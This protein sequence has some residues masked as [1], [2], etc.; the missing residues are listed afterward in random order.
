MVFRRSVFLGEPVISRFV[1]KMHVKVVLELFLDVLEMLPEVLH[2]SWRSWTP[3]P[4]LFAPTAL[5]KKIQALN[6]FWLK[7]GSNSHGFGR[8]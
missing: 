4:L 2:L 7:T 3:P 5:H 8:E 6:V 1:Y